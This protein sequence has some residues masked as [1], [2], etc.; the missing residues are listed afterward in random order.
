MS[1]FPRVLAAIL[2]SFFLFSC[3]SEDPSVSSS[4]YKLIYDF[5]DE[6]SLPDVSLSVFV[7]V[8]SDET[9]GES[10]RIINEKSGL[11]WKCSGAELRKIEANEDNKWV[12]Y[13]NFRPAKDSSF[14][15]GLYSVCYEDKSELE[16][17]S[18]F[19]LLY[20]DEL[21]GAKSSDFPQIFTVPSVKKI[22][23]YSNEDELLFFGEEPHTWE[24]NE[25]ILMELKTAW[26]KR[27]CYC[28]N[29]NSVLCLM[30]PVELGNKNYIK[31]NKSEE[32]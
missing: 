3:S 18:S 17:E 7:A 29:G 24:N 31:E 32:N 23:I 2:L 26:C 4:S 8:E 1:S 28:I 20:P 27:V 5:K 11:E 25:N 9:R 14:P 6:E 16:A 10:L 15:K 22:A 21:A 13:T 12:G 19:R 30:P